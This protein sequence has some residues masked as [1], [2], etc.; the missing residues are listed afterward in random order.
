M[1]SM[2][3]CTPCMKAKRLFDSYGVCYEYIDIDTAT[4]D[5]WEY[6]IDR[7]E[8]FMPGRGIPMVYPMIIVKERKMIQGYDEKSLH[9][10][11]R[12]IVI[13]EQ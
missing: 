9:A 12:E 11:A 4:E 6:A 2:S 3:T 10:L 1:V 13:E 5:E 8:D 7:L